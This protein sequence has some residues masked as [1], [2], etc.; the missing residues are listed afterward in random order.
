MMAPGD[1]MTTVQP[2]FFPFQ[3]PYQYVLQKFGL[4]VFG[5]LFIRHDTPPNRKPP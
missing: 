3:Y 1:M 2:E 5:F 4:H